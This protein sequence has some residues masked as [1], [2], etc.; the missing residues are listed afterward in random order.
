MNSVRATIS[1]PTFAFRPCRIPSRAPAILGSAFG[2]FSLGSDPASTGFKVRDLNLPAGVDEKR[3]AERKDIRAAV[4]EH[5]STLEKSDALD[6]M[7]SFYQRAY[8]M[9]SSD[10]ARAA[11]CDHR[12]ETESC[13]TNMDERRPASGCYSRAVSSRRACGSCR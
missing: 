3:F 8:S 11:F 7:D 9:L 2:P 1:R 5:F 6:G 4:D 12:R 13:A 10:K